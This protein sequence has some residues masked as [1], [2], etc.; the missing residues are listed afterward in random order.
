[1]SHTFSPE[2]D[3][4]ARSR[5]PTQ[6]EWG[7]RPLDE[8]PVAVA[9]RVGDVKRAE[10]FAASAVLAAAVLGV[11]VFFPV[12]GRVMVLFHGLL[13]GLLG[14]ATFVLPLGLALAGTVGFIR[15]AQPDLVLPRRRI[16]GLGLI[17]I[18]LLP[19]E[20]LLG[21]S[22][23]LLGEWFTGFLIDLLGAP[24]AVVLLTALLAVGV[25]LTFDPR[26]WRWPRAA[27]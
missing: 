19:A 3:R 10:A 8:T 27:G 16:I 26:R 18:A 24:A 23:G 9:A 7:L 5:P 14:H 13:E 6:F 22:T 15:R 12:E 25:D 11:I 21:Q 20:R 1:M 2:A 4:H 17:T